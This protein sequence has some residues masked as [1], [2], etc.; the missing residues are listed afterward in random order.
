[1]K[2]SRVLWGLWLALAVVF[3]MVTDSM[4]GYL[5]VI[6]SV[7]VPL[8]AALPVH[9]TAKRLDAELTLSAYGEKGTEIAGKLLLHNK[10]IFSADRIL[11]RISC[12]NLLTGE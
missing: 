12:E 4:A 11:C 6:L 3:C 1:M 2:K 10:S 7:L 5:L 9:Q 8:L